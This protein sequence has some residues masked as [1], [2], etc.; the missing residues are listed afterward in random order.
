M[1][2]FTKL[3]ADHSKI[4]LNPKNKKK[5]KMKSEVLK[6]KRKDRVLM[7]VSPANLIIEDGFNVRKDYGNL[8]ELMTSIVECGLQVPIK[9]KEL[10]DDSEKW[11]VIDGHRRLLAI[12]LAIE[13][14]HDIKYVDVLSFKGNDEDQVLSM[15]ITGTGQKPLNEMEQSNAVQRLINFGYRVDEIAKKMGR[16]LP[17]VYY[18]VKLSAI[19]MKLKEKVQEGYISGLALTSIMENAP[20]DEWED[21]VEQAISNANENAP[22]GAIVKA[23]AK[24]IEDR[25]LRPIEKL[26]KLVEFINA[27]EIENEKCSLLNEL[28]VRL[29]EDDSIDELAEIFKN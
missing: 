21:R 13:N 15:L 25:K 28:W 17:H 6:T 3:K 2:E 23:T 14:G 7:Q 5:N 12:Q 10:K 16:S 8:E 29:I 4:I 20:E 26:A 1:V 22:L 18:L 24:N 27:E 19:P 9:A 11:V